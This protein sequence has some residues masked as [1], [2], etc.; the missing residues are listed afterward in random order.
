MEDLDK[1]RP[2]KRPIFYATWSFAG[3]GEGRL[4]ISGRPLPGKGKRSSGFTVSVKA[5]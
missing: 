4:F 5:L 1:I 2:F 3:I